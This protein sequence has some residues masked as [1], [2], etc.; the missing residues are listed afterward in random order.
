VTQARP[1]APAPAGSCWT[2]SSTVSQD[3]QSLGMIVLLAKRTA[4]TN[5][6]SPGAAWTVSDARP[7]NKLT[8]AVPAAPRGY[9]E[10]RNPSRDGPST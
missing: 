5:V 2:S 3:E 1:K 7:A 8:T 9:E 10:I 6:A 4:S